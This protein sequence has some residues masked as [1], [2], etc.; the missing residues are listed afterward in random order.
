MLNLNQFKLIKKQTS[1]YR[2][3]SNVTGVYVKGIVDFLKFFIF[4]DFKKVNF[5]LTCTLVEFK[6]FCKIILA[7]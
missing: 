1:F 2:N 5:P 6:H 7:F 3:V 4:K